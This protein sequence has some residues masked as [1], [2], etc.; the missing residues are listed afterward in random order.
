V[1]E[2]FAK[3]M[4]SLPLF[5]RA[6]AEAWG[7][8]LEGVTPDPTEYATAGVANWTLADG[9]DTIVIGFTQEP[10]SMNNLVESAAV[11]RQAAQI[12]VGV[13][14]TQFSYDYQPVLQTELSTIEAGLATNEMVTVGPGDMIFSADGEAV[15]LAEGAR[16]VQ[17]GVTVEYDGS[18]ELELPQLTVTYSINPYTWSDGTPGSIADVE[19]AYTHNCDP[20][21]GATS[22][23]TCDSIQDIAYSDSGDISWIITYL[24]GAQDPTYYLMP[25]SISPTAPIYPSHQVVSDGRNLADIPAEEWLTLPEIAETPLSYGPFY[26]TEWIK[27]QSMTFA[28]N[29]YYEGGTGVENVIIVFVA[30][31]NQAVAQ[32]LSGDVDYLDKS[33]L[34]AG[35]E[36]QTVVDAAAEGRVNVEVGASPTWEHID[37]NL[38]IE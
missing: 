9:G 12:G 19:L 18:S 20:N 16:Y 17:D 14:N 26:I 21:S 7:L 4:I 28:A 27:G 3:D 36:V 38:N 15:E 10:A 8:N 32:L 30:D 31:T 13:A 34:G 25:F 33:T 6:E 2:E 24:P 5:Q 1:Q 23:T 22:F 35:A 11:Q 29:P 37:M